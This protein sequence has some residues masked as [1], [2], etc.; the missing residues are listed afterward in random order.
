MKEKDLLVN[1]PEHQLI[2][3]A[4]KNDGTYGPVQTGS[5]MAGN[6][7]SEHYKIVGN[8]NK[9]LIERLQ[10]GEISPIYYY[11]MI[12]DLSVS[13]LAGRTGI[14]KICVKKHITPKGFEK[15]SISKLK[16]YADVLNIPLAN[17]FQIIHTIEDRNWDIG[18]QEDIGSSKSTSISQAK[19]KN[20]FLVET[21][22]IQKLK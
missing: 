18:Y 11:M 6:H 19:T 5:Y 22:V 7:I 2:L 15:V 16:R 9:S 1:C 3:Y 17:M 10:N 20:Q 14:S 13:E 12:E 4:E 21:K 8:L